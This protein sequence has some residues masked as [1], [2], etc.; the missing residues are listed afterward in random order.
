MFLH[1]NF[2]LRPFD[3]SIWYLHVT[4]Q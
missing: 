2:K 4:D 1:Y 3:W